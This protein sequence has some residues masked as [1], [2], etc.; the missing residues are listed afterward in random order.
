M[1][2]NKLLAGFGIRFNKLMRTACHFLV[3]LSHLCVLLG[4]AI[5]SFTGD[6]RGVII[7]ASRRDEENWNRQ[8]P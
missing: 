1:N 8:D 4:L 7:T 3:E 5:G 6:L 2:R